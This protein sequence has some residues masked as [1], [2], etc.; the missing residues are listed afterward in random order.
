MDKVE[1]I[2]GWIKVAVLKSDVG[3]VD[4]YALLDF[5]DDLEFEEE[6]HKKEK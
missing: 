3:D 4:G 1:A 5:I 2:K 6:T